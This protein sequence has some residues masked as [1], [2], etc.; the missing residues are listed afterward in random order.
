MSVDQPPG[1][2]HAFA[3]RWP[4]S[5]FRLGEL[6]V[7]SGTVEPEALEIAL[8]RQ[9]AGSRLPIG[10]LLIEMGAIS[11]DTLTS[12]L[13]QQFRLP[14]LHPD[15]EPFDPDAVA[16]LPAEAAVRLQALPVRYARGRLVIAVAEPPTPS[17]RPLLEKCTGT[18]VTLALAPADTLAHA[19]TERYAASA[20]KSEPTSTAISG[21]IETKQ[22]ETSATDHGYLRPPNGQLIEAGTDTLDF[23][24]LDVM[25]SEDTRAES[26]IDNHSG[27][28]G[29]RTQ[30]EV[31]RAERQHRSELRAVSWLLGR[32]SQLGASSIELQT[33]QPD[34]L[35]VRFR[36]DGRFRSEFSLS[37]DAGTTLLTRVMHAASLDPAATPLQKGRLDLRQFRDATAASVTALGSDTGLTVLVRL[38]GADAELTGL[39]ERVAPDTVAAI[40]RVLAARH[41]LV[42]VGAPLASDRRQLVASLLTEAQLPTRSVVAIEEQRDEPIAGTTRVMGDPSDALGAALALDPDIVIISRPDEVVLNARAVE[43]ALSERL[44]FTANDA[45]DPGSALD[46]VRA[47]ADPFLVSAAVTLIITARSGIDRLEGVGEDVKVAPDEPASDSA[48]STIEAV[49]ITEQLRESIW[50]DTELNSIADAATHLT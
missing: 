15:R 13:A 9:E 42:V 12:T 49:V 22:G 18:P 27:G 33:V 20:V 29:D 35:R 4:I 25:T 34:V 43:L 11:E 16:R 28:D 23:V 40:R 5:S 38:E 2:Q 21:D 30:N 41:G 50:H 3:E 39:G 32:A 14:V 19:I 17:L 45:P 44:V 31:G 8:R 10:R 37:G 7:R 47:S 48:L 24:P 6:L 36:I 46:R 26:V 1:E